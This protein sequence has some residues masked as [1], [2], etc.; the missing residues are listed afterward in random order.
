M[1]PKQ[2]PALRYIDGLLS[3]HTYIP[4]DFRMW[5]LEWPARMAISCLW[6]GIPLVRSTHNKDDQPHGVIWLPYKRESPE[7][8]AL[9]F[10]RRTPHAR[11]IPALLLWR[12]DFRTMWLVFEK[13]DEQPDL[14]GSVL[15]LN[16]QMRGE[17]SAVF[18][19]RWKISEEVQWAYDGLERGLLEDLGAILSFT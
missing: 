10:K 6:P 4:E 11:F 8:L 19:D 15:I 14:F 17:T 12:D 7:L 18:P 13:D 9:L 5:I 1:A 3:Q 16:D 2:P